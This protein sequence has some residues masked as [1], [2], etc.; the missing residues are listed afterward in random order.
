M[1]RPVLQAGKTNVWNSISE[2]NESEFSLYPNPTADVLNIFPVNL[3]QEYDLIL[4]DLSGREVKRENSQIG[5]TRFVVSDLSSG[6][7]LVEVSHEGLL[8]KRHQFIK[9]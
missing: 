8:P 6:A 5:Q 2:L 7:Y 4:F 1:I 3:M 9:Q